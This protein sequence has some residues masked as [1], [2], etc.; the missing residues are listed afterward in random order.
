MASDLAPSLRE[1][2][3]AL[4][5]AANS[6]DTAA[7]AAATGALPAF[8]AKDEFVAKRATDVAQLVG[9]GGLSA[10]N[11]MKLR[12]ALKELADAPVAADIQPV[13]DVIST[14][15]PLIAP[16]ATCALMKS[17]RLPPGQ[18]GICTK[19]DL[20]SLSRKMASISMTHG[21]RSAC[22][23]Y[24]SRKNLRASSSYGN[25]FSTAWLPLPQSTL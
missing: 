15:L 24:S 23:R 9:S 21:C 2:A 1:A 5:V 7:A 17:S 12:D 8:A 18:N 13:V 4:R 19:S 14:S 16:A 22:R 3:Q 11:E 10:Y 20:R 6:L 25:S